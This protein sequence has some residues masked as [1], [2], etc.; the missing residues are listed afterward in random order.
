MFY[1]FQ[2]G[3]LI[4]EFDDKNLEVLRQK[5]VDQNCLNQ[6]YQSLKSKRP[7]FS[8]TL[9]LGRPLMVE[10]P[11]EYPTAKLVWILSIHNRP[12]FEQRLRVYLTSLVS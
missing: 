10:Y 12:A 4:P 9:C 11:D 6:L 5:A 8:N 1:E 2:Q 3:K 7:F